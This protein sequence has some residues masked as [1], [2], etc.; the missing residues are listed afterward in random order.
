VKL[1]SAERGVAMPVVEASLKYLR[2]AHL[3]DLLDVAVVLDRIGPASVAADYE[4]A[5]CG[6]LLATGRTRMAV[7]EADTGRAIQ[8]PN[9][10]RELL[11]G[12]GG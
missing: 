1:D 2:Q 9:W 5:R 7:I 10:V 8:L 4:V 6:L 11:A 3:D 12:I